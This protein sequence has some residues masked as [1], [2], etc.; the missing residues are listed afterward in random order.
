MKYT[1]CKL[2][3]KAL[4]KKFQKISKPC[5]TVDQQNLLYRSITQIIKIY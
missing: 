1:T 5:I 2:N 4:L 3:E